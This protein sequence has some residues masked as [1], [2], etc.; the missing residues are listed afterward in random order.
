MKD[1][2]QFLAD[3]ADVY[4][5]PASLP[6]EKSAWASDARERFF[7]ITDRRHMVFGLTAQIDRLSRAVDVMGK[8]AAVVDFFVGMG[9]APPTNTVLLTGPP[10]TGKTAAV[11]AVVRE[12]GV[13]MIKLSCTKV[14]SS[15]LGSTGN[16]VRDAIDAAV[17]FSEKAGGAILFFDEFEALAASRVDSERS[18]V[19]ETARVV[20]TI[21][22]ALDSVREA[23][24]NL[25]IIAA[26]NISNRLDPA[27]V[28]RF[29][30]R[31]SF[32][33]L[34]APHKERLLYSLFVTAKAAKLV[35]GDFEVPAGLLE[36]KKFTADDLYKGVLDGLMTSAYEVVMRGTCEML[37][38]KDII[39]KIVRRGGTYR[40]IEPAGE[41]PSETEEPVSFEAVEETATAVFRLRVLN[42]ERARV[43]KELSDAATTRGRKTA[44]LAEDAELIKHT[45]RLR[46]LVG[47][48]EDPEGGYF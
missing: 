10:G 14:V 20:T 25:A 31:L 46:K 1:P 13:P 4:L 38:W 44:L 39:G 42:S 40:E 47:E 9:L 5:P 6:D 43:K 26:T 12:R 27:V 15:L 16:N 34:P 29:V 37:L 19:M 24:A 17:K 23:R 30:E 36:P 33:D 28:R 18:D 8:W 11:N 2:F 7:R 3:N 32:H 21:L 48:P 35:A 22:T 45:R 41:P